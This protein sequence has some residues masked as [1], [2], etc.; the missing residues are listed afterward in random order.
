MTQ[1]SDSSAR[2]AE[3]PINHLDFLKSL[4]ERD[5]APN[6]T[7]SVPLCVTFRG[8]DWTAATNGKAFTLLRGKCAP[9]TE[10]SQHIEAL[11]RRSW[12][13][14]R[15]VSWAE[16]TKFLDGAT[17]AEFADCAACKGVHLGKRCLAC[18][19]DGVRF[20][21]DCGNSGNC[22]TCRGFGVVGA[23]KECRDEPAATPAAY[24]FAA[25][26]VLIN[27]NVLRRYLSH[28]SAESVDFYR[29][30]E[31]DPVFFESSDWLVCVMPCKLD[32]DEAA[33][34]PLL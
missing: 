33:V 18:G 28:L 23:C 26:S 13:T 2:E 24:G 30:G 16:L 14:P 5:A 27:R 8:G 7:T 4:C 25:P 3:A 10:N 12:G 20:C 17:V 11:L 1:S 22:K 6:R 31:L 19:G 15:A 34:G 29:S 32:S 9:R 21:D